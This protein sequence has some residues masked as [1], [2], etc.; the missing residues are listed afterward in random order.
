MRLPL[1]L[2][3]LAA[4][5]AL[6][7]LHA[8]DDHV[9]V[10]AHFDQ[11]WSVPELMPMIADLGVGWIRD[12]VPWKDIE[13][14]ERAVPHSG[15]DHCVARC[16]A[17]A[18]SQGAAA[19]WLREQNLRRSV[20]ARCLRAG[21]GIPGYAAG[22]PHRRH[23]GAQRAEQS[24]LRPHLRRQVERQGGRWVRLALRARLRQ[25]AD[26]DGRGGEEGEPAPA[27]R[28]LWRARAGVV[29]HDCARD[30]AAARRHHRSSLLGRPQAAGTDSLRRHA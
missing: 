22:K 3:G 19:A 16:G 23:R 9:G 7:A 18:S 21:S 11:G 4:G 12:G 1:R 30:A 2:L 6:T 13:A 8:A 20:F 25:R 14:G 26:R 15:A 24:R 29:P 17:C 27:R 28:R 5:L 10:C